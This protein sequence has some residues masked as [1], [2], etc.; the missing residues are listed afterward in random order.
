MLSFLPDGVELV[1][2]DDPKLGSSSDTSSNSSGSLLT[3]FPRLSSLSALTLPSDKS[4]T[5]ERQVSFFE[6]RIG[7]QRQPYLL[8]REHLFFASVP[9]V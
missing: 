2:E 4:L 3:Q 9:S 1:I 7:R 8:Y 5:E 6:R